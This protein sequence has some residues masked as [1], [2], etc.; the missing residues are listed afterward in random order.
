MK[1]TR[2][3]LAVA[4]LAIVVPGLSRAADARPGGPGTYIIGGSAAG[5]TEFPFMAALLNENARGSDYDK[6]F[7]GGSLI[8]ARW[9][10]TA[11]HCVEGLSPSDLAVTVGRAALNSNDGE[12]HS[13]AAIRVH[14]TYDVAVLQLDGDSRFTPIR[15]STDSAQDQALENEGTTLTVIGWG[16]VRTGKPLYPNQLQKVNV[17]VVSDATCQGAYGAQLDAIAEVCAGSPGLDS[18]YGD[19]GG[20][21]FDNRNPTARVQVGI[22]SWGNGCA[23]KRF[24][25]VYDEV[26]NAVIRAWIRTN[27]GA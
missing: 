21:L 6:Q 1:R 13:L 12:R 10:L 9:V 25:G 17:P 24:P 18:C 7:C 22:V 23:K 20:P 27:T 15:L 16:T 14:P 11:A 19:S 2:L 3:A 8:T 5:P 4:L 26:N